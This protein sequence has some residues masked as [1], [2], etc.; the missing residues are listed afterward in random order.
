MFFI[1]TLSYVHFEGTMSEY[2]LP[3]LKASNLTED[4]K[5]GSKSHSGNG[6]WLCGVFMSIQHLTFSSA[7][8]FI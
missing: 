5:T 4:E 3:V 1:M 6:Q 8:Y 7:G 2:V